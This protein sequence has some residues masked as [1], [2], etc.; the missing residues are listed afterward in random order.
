MNN[1]ILIFG[2]QLSEDISSLRKAKADDF[3][4]MVE[5]KSET[6]KIQH[7]R[8]KIVFLFSAMRHFFNSVVPGKC[9]GRYYKLDD[10]DNQQDF[11]KNIQVLCTRHEFEKVIMTE[12]S[13]YGLLKFMHE[14]LQEA[15]LNY[16]ILED[17]RFLISK[18]EFKEFASQRKS[19]KME[20]FYRM[21]REKTSYLM[22]GNKPL[23]NKWNYDHNNRKPWDGKTPI[24][25]RPK[26]EV[27]EITEE[28]LKLVEKEFPDRFGSIDDFCHA[29]TRNQALQDL[30]C[31]VEKCLENYGKFQDAM[32]VDESY[33]FHSRISHLINCGLLGVREVCEKVLTKIDAAP[34]ASIEGFIRQVIGWREYIR[35]VYWLKMPSYTEENY[36]GADK[37]LPSFYWSGNCKMNCMSSVV[38]M[39]EKTAYSHHIQRLMITGN[40]ALLAGINPIEVHEW[41]LAVYDDAY[42]WVELPNTLGMALYADGGDMSTKPYAASGNYINKMSNF[43]KSCQY[44]VKKK[45]GPEACPFNYLYWNFLDKNKD[46]L[47]SNRRLR[48]PYSTLTKKS[49][50][51]IRQIRLDSQKFLREI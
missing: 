49:D 11:I 36:F 1:L 19:L 40:F 47:S 16:E 41:Y 9:Q 20:D 6:D 50:D 24:P 38:K 12:P 27:D 34:L 45:A 17:D 5:T 29:V 33:L 48:M 37:P 2:D 46:L 10:A 13:E 51:D 8:R 31:F 15:D 44:D 23:G 3:I 35:G 43:C 30:D 22:D 14:S 28:V 42:E 4:V 32:L 25:Q 18:A 26:H 39:T 7:H 21:M